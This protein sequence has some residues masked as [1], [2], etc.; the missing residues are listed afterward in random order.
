LEGFGVL[1]GQNGGVDFSQKLFAKELKEPNEGN[2][3]NDA[4]MPLYFM[5]GSPCQLDGL[6]CEKAMFG[7]LLCVQVVM[8]TFRV[9]YEFLKPNVN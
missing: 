2:V 7:Q 9:E 5:I 4:L 1:R 6:A 3:G 8:I